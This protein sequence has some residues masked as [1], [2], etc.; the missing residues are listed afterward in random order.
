M[1][2]NKKVK[3]ATA[4]DYKG[5]K[6]KSLMEKRA[7]ELLESEGLDPKYELITYTLVRGFYPSVPFYKKSNK[8]FNIDK[9]KIR[10]ITYTPDFVVCKDGY[11]F[12]IEMKGFAN[13]TYPIKE[14]LFRKHL[15][16]HFKGENIIVFLVKSIK[17]LK[18][19]VNIIKNSSYERTERVI[20]NYNR[21]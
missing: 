14:K 15:E 21:T 10:D 19:V 12:L 3:N 18:E 8:G 4:C 17:E 7:F 5:I 16:E 13:D 11:I 2:E 9:I 20:S 6:F 1:T